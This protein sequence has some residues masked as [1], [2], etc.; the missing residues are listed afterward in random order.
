MKK[1]IS[2]SFL[3]KHCKHHN[4]YKLVNR[5]SMLHECGLIHFISTCCT[6]KNCPI[7]KK[8]Q[9]VDKNR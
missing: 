8:L 6:T 3:R 2:F 7:W 4:V 9:T 5:V 1:L